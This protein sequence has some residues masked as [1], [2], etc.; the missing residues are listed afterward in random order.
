M[1]S[2]GWAFIFIIAVPV[3]LFLTWAFFRV[4]GGAWYYGRIKAIRRW[5]EETRG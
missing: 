4:A 5:R 2:L 1:I 3:A